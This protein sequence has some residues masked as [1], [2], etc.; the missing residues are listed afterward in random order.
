MGEPALFKPA[1]RSFTRD[2]RLTVR[3]EVLPDDP[4]WSPR[5]LPVIIHT[6]PLSPN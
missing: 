3:A 5:N 4:A 6:L 2:A 1:N